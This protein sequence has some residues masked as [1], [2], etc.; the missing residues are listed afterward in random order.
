MLGD[1]FVSVAVPS[2]SDRLRNALGLVS[3]I[4]PPV[5][6]HTPYSNPNVNLIKVNHNVR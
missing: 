2:T 6:H 4:I 3:E 5:N 1:S